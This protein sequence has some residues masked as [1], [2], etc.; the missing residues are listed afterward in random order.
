[1]F[2]KLEA[3]SL[4]QHKALRYHAV[5][6]YRFAEDQQAVPIAQGEW[7]EAAKHYAI[8]FPPAGQG[9]LPLALLGLVP[10]VNGFVGEGGR[11]EAP[12]VPA[13]VQRFP[14]MLA[15][16]GREDQYAVMVDREAPH[17]EGE[18]GSPLFSDAGEP[19]PL[20][21][22]V[23]EFLRGFQEQA[24][25]TRQVVETLRGAEVL[26]PQQVTQRQGTTQRPLLTGFEVVDS[27]RL[28]AVSDETFLDWRRRNILPLVYAHLASL[29]NLGR[30]QRPSAEGQTQH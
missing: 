2:R 3:L 13:H 17:F 16:T 29:T 14:F 22:R 25:V 8:V 4:E 27:A 9:E 24:L 20:L 28:G 12:Y 21:K 5:Q 23:K 15:Q 7:L 30:L 1:M 26:I 19:A 11:W 10:G 6:G 18:E